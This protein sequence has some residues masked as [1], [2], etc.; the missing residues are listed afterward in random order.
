MKGRSIRVTAN[1]EVGEELDLGDPGRSIGDQFI[2]RGRLLSVDDPDRVVG[3]FSEVCIITDLERNAGLCSLTAVLEKGQIAVQGEQQ[4]IPAPVSVTNAITGGTGE[5]RKAQGQM[6]LRVL[7]AATWD[8][9]FQL[10][11]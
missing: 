1:V 4:G 11:D 9:T 6:T 8:I 3:R 5:F 7:S 2:F 10:K